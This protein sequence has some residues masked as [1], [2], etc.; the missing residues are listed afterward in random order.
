M[1]LC[2]QKFFFVEG[3]GRKK[4][5]VTGVC[6]RRKYKVVLIDDK[7]DGTGA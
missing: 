2:C 7:L 3:V 6:K 1:K 4:L 5:T